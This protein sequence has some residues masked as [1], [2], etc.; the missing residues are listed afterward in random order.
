[1]NHLRLLKS[2][3]KLVFVLCAIAGSTTLSFGQTDCLPSNVVTINVV[4][5]PTINTQ[6]ISLTECVGGNLS[7]TIA[8]SGGT[9]SLSYQWQ[10][11]ADG[12]TGWANVTG[13]T[14]AT[15]TTYTPVSTGAGVIY[16]RV[17]VSATGNDCNTATSNVVTATIV[18]DPA[19]TTQPTS[20]VECIGG[21][22]TMT[23]IASGGTP[24]LN[25]Q[26]Q[27]SADG[28]TGWAN[29][30]GGSGAN[31]NVYT[32]A[33]TSTGT[34]YY[35]VLVSATGNDCNTAT[36]SVVTAVISPQLSVTTQPLPIT[37]CVGGNLTM[38][39]AVAGAVGSV[40][41]AWEQSTNGTTG[42]TAA[43]G[44]S[45][46]N[47]ATYTP[48][49]ATAGTMYYRAVVSAAGNGCSNATSNAALSTI[50]ADPAITTQ[51]TSITECVGGNLTMTVVASGGTPSLNYQWQQSAD[52]STGWA[53][54][55]GGTGATTPTYTPVS[56]GVG[57]IYYRV[58]VSATGNDCNTATSSTVT[59]TIVADPAITTQPL[60]IVECIG[61]TLTMTVAASGGTPSLNYQWQQSADGSTGWINVTGGSGANT[62]VYTPPST[63]SGT[64]Y[65]RVL[66]SATGNDCNTATSNVVTAIISPQLSVTTQPQPIT[67]CVGGNLTMSVV[68]A[69]AVGS[70]TYAWE[71]SANGT[72]GWTAAVGGS[73]ANTATYT[74]PSA[75]AGTMYYRAVVSAAGNGCS[76][77]TSNAAL[78]TIVADP[79][80]T[81]QPLPITEC[82]GGNLTMTV[83]ATGG[84]PSLN[85][86]WQQS[87]DGSTGWANVTGGTGAT[88]PTYTPVSTSAGVIYY[89]V[90]VS[91]T[92]NDCNTA[93]SS[94]VTA[95]VV[96]DPI[97]TISVDNN[98]ICTSGN[99]NFSS[100]VTGGTGTIS[101]QWQSSPDNATWADIS[102]ATAATYAATS[103]T[104]TTYYRLVVT[105]SGSGCQTIS[106]AS[107]VTVVGQPTVNLTNS[108]PTV[109]VGGNSTLTA[110]VGGGTGTTVYQW[111][112][113]ANGTTGW[114]NIGGANAATYNTGVL[115]TTTYYR[116]IVTQGSGCVTT[117]L[118]T[119]VTVVP[120][121]VVT[122]ST[123]TPT[124][125]KG[126]TADLTSTVTG[127][128]G[129]TL[130]Q[131]QTSADGT[132]WADSTGA[133][134]STLTTTTLD[135]SRYYRLIVTQGSGCQTIS[136]NLQVI[137]VPKPVIGVN[138]AVTNVCVGGGVTITSTTSGGTGT[139]TIQWQSSP[140]GTT[141][142][143]VSGAN[144]ATY[145]TPALNTTTQYRATYRCTGNGCCN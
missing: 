57:V 104:T 120:D 125:C 8:A 15:T 134:N 111:Q 30:T 88:T 136:A 108:N 55:T 98:T 42:W 11:S 113:S 106:S 130:F 138:A 10:Q 93:T 81:V 94:T 36:S 26:W 84:T 31:T 14:G 46:A 60:P 7:F 6:P 76:N 133:T 33:S 53:N 129:T 49:S 77:A 44:G 35:R 32:P 65:Y 112:Q 25:Y 85:Y 95:T 4:P 34:I 142:N 100:T 75:T 92:G 54:V 101:Y 128:T 74:P 109:C 40:T 47:T 145:T 17:L 89:R 62:T 51:P 22:L 24:S 86:Q 131:W 72:T 48:P 58:L 141:W 43:V 69:G 18:A 83:T 102:G 41:Y 23:V 37:E 71:Q 137:V 2:L 99:A 45:G 143:D 140:N 13:G 90:L 144:G 118:A 103:L 79:A 50:V 123:T 20:I 119:V 78:S 116:V 91:A 114:A 73:G 135:A 1:M 66:V 29:V 12:S 96:A 82:I 5:D 115:S 16:Y 132:T 21:T 27:Q 64:I 67:E 124:I 110:S 52:G 3:K 126:G 9:P 59:A 28:S 19:I 70:V 139:C 122:L 107:T 80:I 127:G 56:T 68:V 121:P 39:V 87:A 38:T 97:V 117:S 61:G 63:T 105:Q